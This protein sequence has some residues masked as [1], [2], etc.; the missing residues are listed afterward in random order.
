MMMTII[1][2]NK[3][4]K[5]ERR[6]TCWQMKRNT[7]RALPKR[8]F[9]EGNRGKTDEHWLGPHTTDRETILLPSNRRRNPKLEMNQN[10]IKWKVCQL[11]VQFSP[12]VP[13]SLSP[14]C[15][16]LAGA[17]LSIVLCFFWRPNTGERKKFWFRSSFHPMFGKKLKAN[18]P[19]QRIWERRVQMK[20]SPREKAKLDGRWSTRSGAQ[21][22][23]EHSP[24][25]NTRAPI[26]RERVSETH[27]IHSELFFP[28]KQTPV[29]LLSFISE[30]P[31][32]N[33]EYWTV[34]E[35]QAKRIVKR[36]RGE[37]ICTHTHT[38]S[39]QRKKQNRK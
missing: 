19:R 17:R 34:G 39:W 3:D 20:T 16:S 15:R 31:R 32:L 21:Q 11:V 23:K 12:P 22:E 33:L 28:N 35:G 5:T 10:Q 30:R 2:I 6:L 14:F 8:G 25:N 24:W 4:Q 7:K 26:K 36:S 18:P 9:G 1:A 38:L 37:G 13:L 29:L 27:F